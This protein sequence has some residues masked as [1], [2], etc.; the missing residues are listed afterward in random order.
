MIDTKYKGRAFKVLN[1]TRWVVVVSGPALIEEMRK[2]KEDEFSLHEALDTVCSGFRR[3]FAIP[4]FG[5]TP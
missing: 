5:L 2:T 4:D 3:P 1:F